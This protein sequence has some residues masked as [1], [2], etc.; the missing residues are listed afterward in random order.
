MST[1]ASKKTENEKKQPFDIKR[2]LF[3]WSGALVSSIVFVVILFA[4]ITTIFSVSGHSMDPTLADGEMMLISRLFYEPKPMDIV[5]FCQEDVKVDNTE[6]GRQIPLVKRIIA[7]GGQT[8]TIDYGAGTVTVDGVAIEEDYILEP[9]RQKSFPEVSTTYV[10]EGYVF[11]MGDNR[12][13]SMDSRS[14]SVGVIDE[15]FILGRVLLRLSPLN[16]F[17][18]VKS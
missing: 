10:P 9:M 11:A 4:F 7:V 14:P 6:T 3:E 8:V 5:M 17:G 2:E 13:D 15:R 12:N 16:K 18:L 1:E